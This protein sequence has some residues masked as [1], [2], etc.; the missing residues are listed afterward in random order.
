MLKQAC[1][2]LFRRTAKNSSQRLKCPAVLLVVL[3]SLALMPTASAGVV[4]YTFAS[5]EGG[6]VAVLD[7]DIKAAESAAVRRHDVVF[8]EPSF[9][10][11]QKLAISEDGRTIVMVNEADG[12]NVA[13]IKLDGEGG[14]ASA[15][16]LAVPGV[17]DGVTIFGDRA[18]IWANKGHVT[19]VDLDTPAVEKRINTR[20]LL[21]P[22]G[23][24]VEDIV[25]SPDADYAVFS[26]QK[27]QRGQK[28]LG[29]RLVLVSLPALEV[30]CDLQLPRNKLDL[31]NPNNDKEQG[32]GPEVI[33]L[34]PKLNQLGVTLD[35][36]G[37]FALTDLDK[38][39]GGK[40]GEVTYLSTAPDGAWGTAFPDRLCIVPHP[41]HEQRELAMI[42]NSG[43]VGGGCV[44]D[45]AQREV[46]ARFDCPPGLE[47][48]TY[49][50]A[51]G[52]VAATHPGK[53]KT[54]TPQEVTKEYKPSARVFIFDVRRLDR[55]DQPRIVE[56]P[57]ATD[58][59]EAIDPQAS[60]LVMVTHDA[61]VNSEDEDAEHTANQQIT[62]LD[63]ATG[64]ITLTLE[65]HGDPRR[66]VRR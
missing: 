18:L 63:T 49:L 34:R 31:H 43:Q 51:A 16:L 60:S 55:L 42:F 14:L 28:S 29:N 39:L 1:L 65:A 4:Y 3:L 27:D 33:V 50:P 11:P 12:E 25:I 37:G 66:L 52:L 53:V 32:P 58:R 57:G 19:L 38:A 30:I 45:L 10:N 47:T 54:I 46:I 40:Q 24:K 15:R 41:D 56:L 20:K 9:T 44:V 48:P 21:H 23:H 2:M 35:L 26:L 22:P 62:L 64:K 8:R 13:V 5:D 61:K 7:V 59:L 36:Y 6:G 17:P